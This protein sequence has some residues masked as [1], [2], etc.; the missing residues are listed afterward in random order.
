MQS[1][2]SNIK[3]NYVREL[4]IFSVLAGMRRGEVC[5]LRREQVD[6]ANGTVTIET[7]ATFRTKSGRRR[8]LPVGTEPMKLI[9]AAIARNES[10][11]VFTHNGKE[12]DGR[13]LSKKFR[14]GVRDSHIKNQRLHWHS[15]RHMS[16]NYHPKWTTIRGAVPYQE[17]ATRC[18]K[19]V[20]DSR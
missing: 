13:I 6:F 16:K 9:K 4:A 8:V 19:E 2:L 10:E 20:N 15:L 18:R 11:Y 7:T 17:L 1:V 14:R 12:V 3:E 5:N